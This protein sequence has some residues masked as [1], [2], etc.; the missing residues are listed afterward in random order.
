MPPRRLPPSA[1]LLLVAAALV[2]CGTEAPGDAGDPTASEPDITA[3]ATGGDISFL[4]QI[5][6]HGGTYSDAQGE[7]D[8]LA[9]MVDHGFN[10]ARLKLWHTPEEPYNTLEKVLDMARRIDAAGM[11]F[12]LDFHYSDW[13]ADPQ[14][15]YKPAAWED[16]D[17]QTLTDSVYQYTRDVVAAL[18]A[19]GTP[20]HMVQ[21]GNE[22]RPGMLWP[23]GRVD[24]EY[25]TPEQW[26]RL[27]TLLGAGIRGVKDGANGSAPTPTGDPV[28]MI[29][30]DN[31]AKNEMA[32]PFFQELVDREVDFDVLGLSFYPKWHGTLDE[33]AAN[34]ADLSQRFQR[35]VYVV[36]TAYPWTFEW[37]DDTGNIFGTQEDLHEGFPPTVQSQAD[38]LRQVRETVE[39][40]PGGRGRGVYYW[41]PEW[42][43]VDGVPSAW[44]NAALFDFEGR[45][46]PSM[47]AFTGRS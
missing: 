45:A 22:I 47:D 14:K 17:F 1:P 13:W 26:D 20:P 9:L 27:A 3:F 25:D 46:L 2:G 16:L 4:P 7:K 19:Q 5:E 33:L 41:A 6:D 28:I 35:D 39:N 18:A 8:L 15:Q 36:E 42:I 40:V 23:D 24:G 38:F 34:L 10:S 30:F 32:R 43:A 44:E 29:H 31:G 12:L 21:V 37:D 11:T